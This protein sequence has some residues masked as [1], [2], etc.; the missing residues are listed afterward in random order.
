MIYGLDTDFL[1][2][3]EITNHP[4]HQG[5]DALVSRLIEEGHALG[6]V[7]QTLAEFIHVVTDSN[8]MPKPLSMSEAIDRAEIWWHAEE[9]VRVFSDE[10]CVT[11]FF[12]LLRTYRL[13]RKRLLD[14]LLAAS[15]HRAHIRQ[16]VTNNGNDFRILG[17]FEII[18]F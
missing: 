13:G 11:N 4:F 12:A 15:F 2:A 6:L 17:D 18:T 1:V 10:H 14:T 5:A 16:I 9:V 3:V 8:R 7:P